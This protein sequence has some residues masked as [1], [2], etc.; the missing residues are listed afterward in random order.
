[1]QRVHLAHSAADLHH[2]SAATLA[3]AQGE[4]RLELLSGLFDAAEFPA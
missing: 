2:V 4:G 1:M 3:A